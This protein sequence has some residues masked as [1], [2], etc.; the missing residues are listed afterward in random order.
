MLKMARSSGLIVQN[1]QFVSL[2]MTLNSNLLI[3]GVLISTKNLNFTYVES[4]KTFTMTG[5]ASVM[6][7]V[8]ASVEVVF[9]G[10]GTKGL[11]V[12]NGNLVS[13]DMSVNASVLGVG[14]YSLG[15]A[16][17]KFTYSASTS[18]F[19]MTGSAKIGLP[20]LGEAVV[21][22]GGDGTS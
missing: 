8:L 18:L 20:E 17:M 21:T 10:G 16:K 13:L 3:N 19:T 22:L 15:S 1:G 5:T 12:T 7:P 14:P 6:V 2:D 4:T 9:G 11:V